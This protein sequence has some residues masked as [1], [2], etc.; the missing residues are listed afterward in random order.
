M[1]KI[2][3]NIEIHASKEKVWDVMLAD[4]TYREWTTDFQPG[5]YYEGSWD[6]GSDIRF[7]APGKD[8]LPSGMISKIVRNIPNEYISIEHLGQVI[9]GKDD[10]ESDD[11]KQW[12]GAHENYLLKETDG[13]TELTIELEGGNVSQEMSDMLE[14]AWPAALEKLKHIAER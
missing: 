8:G 7:L 13:V 6:E 10:T 14:A 12:V 3:F 9:D 1:I 5:S 2:T 11:A 4:Q